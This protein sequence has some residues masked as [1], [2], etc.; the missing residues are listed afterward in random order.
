M[1]NL[2][3]MK[4]IEEDRIRNENVI[5]AKRIAEVQGTDS[6]NMVLLEIQRYR[7]LKSRC[8]DSE[9]FDPKLCSLS[10]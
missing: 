1:E 2:K 9:R 8:V 7:D 6:R 4:K 10:N 3:L 5:L